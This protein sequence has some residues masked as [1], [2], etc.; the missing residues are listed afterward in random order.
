MAAI[1]VPNT[2]QWGQLSRGCLCEEG[3]SACWF[4]RL[5]QCFSPLLTLCDARDNQNQLYMTRRSLGQ[6]KKAGPVT[7]KNTA[8]TQAIPA[9]MQQMPP[10]NAGPCM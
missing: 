3:S 10:I 6:E 5:S 2:S 9:K 4:F 7:Y 1:V 8:R